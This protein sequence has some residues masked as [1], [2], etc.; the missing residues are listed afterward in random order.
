MLIRGFGKE[1][2]KEFIQIV[3]DELRKF[4]GLCWGWEVFLQRIQGYAYTSGI[5]DL[6]LSVTENVSR[7][8]SSPLWAVLL[9]S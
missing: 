9:G 7:G 4:Q 2:G 1:G 6:T 5:E 3:S 8:F